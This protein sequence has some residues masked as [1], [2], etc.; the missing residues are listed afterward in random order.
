MRKVNVMTN[1][2]DPPEDRDQHP[3]NR[4]DSGDG[5][6]G[7]FPSYPSYPSTPHPEDAPGYAGYS[8]YSGYGAADW[9]SAGQPAGTQP[10]GTGRV[11]AMAAVR[12]AFS[13]VFRN[14]K[15]WILGM[16]ALLVV[17]LIVSAVGEFLFPTSGGQVPAEFS[18]GMETGLNAGG[19]IFQLLYGVASVVVTV[20][21]YHGALRQVDKQDLSFRDFTG[22][23][24]LGP[25]VGLYI[26]LQ[27]LMVLVLAVILVPVALGGGLFAVDQLT[28]Q[29]DFLSFLGVVLGLLL[30]AVVLSLLV[31][32]LTQLMIWY[33]ID[34]R[35]SFGG[36]I[37][38]GFRAGLNNYGR[39]L[40]FNLVAG[41]VMFLGAMVTL[42]LALLILGPAYLLTLAMMYRQASGGALPV[43][44]R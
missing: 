20:L 18:P 3:E 8:G 32:P 14:W 44:A 12:W 35:A 2:F 1:P 15:I 37:K 33:V 25:A 5:G 26:L 31:T 43:D 34:R 6:N 23:V 30:V 41:I 19:L 11:D 39:L 21:I 9:G 10:Q 22:N 4:G 40:V 36:A 29:D 7:G 24:N 13:A 17:S 28:S 27:F 16:L 42:G 38:E